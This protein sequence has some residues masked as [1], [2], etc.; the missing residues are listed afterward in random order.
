MSSLSGSWVGLLNILMLPANETIYTPLKISSAEIT[1]YTEFIFTQ[2]HGNDS[3]QYGLHIDICAYHTAVHLAQRQHIQQV[4]KRGAYN[5]E[6]HGYPYLGGK[7]V[8]FN[9][10]KLLKAEQS[11]GKQPEEE[12]PLNHRERMVF[13][14]QRPHN[15]QVNGIRSGVDE[16][17]QI[18]QQ[19]LAAKLKSRP[20]SMTRTA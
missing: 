20:A 19:G 6:T 2:C 7:R 12:H 14:H 10:R 13:F 18:A 9:L 5:N 11:N 4:G 8:P 1:F 17:K 15:N 16:N 3:G